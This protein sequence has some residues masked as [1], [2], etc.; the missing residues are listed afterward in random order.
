MAWTALIIWLSRTVLNI[1]AATAIHG[2]YLPGDIGRIL[3]QKS[4]R[5]G[6][7]VRLAGTFKQAVCGDLAALGFVLPDSAFWPDY[8]SWRNRVYTHL[9]G[10][11][12]G[13]RAG[14]RNQSG[15]GHAI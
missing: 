1:D 14:E 15:F 7:I 6:N 5:P 12:L 11:F 13:E 2:D 3:N 10:Q 8:G 9:R 4:H